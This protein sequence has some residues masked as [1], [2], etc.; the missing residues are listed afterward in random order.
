MVGPPPGPPKGRTRPIAEVQE[1][2]LRV[3]AELLINPKLSP[4][5]RAVKSWGSKLES[6]PG[7]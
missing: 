7:G 3:K 2:H 4:A 6:K 1:T 5:V